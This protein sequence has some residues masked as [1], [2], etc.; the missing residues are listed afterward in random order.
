VSPKP[1]SRIT[2]L[3]S[4]SLRMRSSS[5]SPSWTGIFMSLMTSWKPCGIS[6]SASSAPEA[7]EQL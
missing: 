7:H 1:V 2:E 6:A 5:Q 3:S 4:W